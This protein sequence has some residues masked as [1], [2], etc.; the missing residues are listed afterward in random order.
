[1]AEVVVA[2]GLLAFALT[3]IVA[4]L[5]AG[6]RIERESLRETRSAELARQVFAQLRGTSF[7]AVANSS[8][9]P[10]AGEAEDATPAPPSSHPTALVDLSA[11][12]DGGE[13]LASWF[14]T[15][16]GSLL[17]GPVPPDS[18]PPGTAVFVVDLRADSGG[19][20]GIPAGR[21][22]RVYADVSWPAGR[23]RRER[24]GRHTFT[25]LL[26]GY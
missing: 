20:D 26:H 10:P 12:S 14:A 13:V 24:S 22:A 6:L 25:T 2:L 17:D 4:L 15:A 8:A 9:F 18:A 7:R 11:R 3:G 23:A 16:D 5:P 19:V 21:A 1:M